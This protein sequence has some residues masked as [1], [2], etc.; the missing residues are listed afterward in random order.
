MKVWHSLLIFLLVWELIHL[1]YPDER[2]DFELAGYTK[3]LLL[4]GYLASYTD[5]KR[6]VDNFSTQTG[7]KA[8][9]GGRMSKL[10][11]VTSASRLP[12]LGSTSSLFICSTGAA[13]FIDAGTSGFS[14]QSN[15]CHLLSD[16]QQD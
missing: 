1:L 4:S 3:Y 13:K 11:K 2:L 6:D 7:K 10:P 14:T 5:P 15:A 12:L 8:K 16:R 9:K